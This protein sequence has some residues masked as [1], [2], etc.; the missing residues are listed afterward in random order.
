MRINT[1]RIGALLFAAA[2]ISAPASAQIVQSL[3]FGG[4]V[5][6]P[7]GEDS[8]ASG[9]VLATDLNEGGLTFRL[10]DLN[11]GHAFGEWLVGVG[12][13]L[14]FGA[15]LGFSSGSA[16]SFYT[17][18]AHPDGS[19]ITQDLKLRTVPITGVVRFLANRPGMFQP[20]FG[21]GIAAVN[22]R[23]TESGEFAD[24]GQVDST[25]AFV[26]FPATYTASGTAVGPVVLAGFRVPLG[27]DIWGFTMEWRHYGLAGDA[28]TGNTGGSN[29]GFLADKI[30][31]G[32]SDINFGLLLRF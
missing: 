18:Y 23:Y 5:F 13:H 1:G 21:V 28:P 2:L 10:S 11:S 27:G 14:E 26:T 29:A 7:R 9:D 31:L 4:G 12:D 6:V 20:Y 17:D 24:F 25:G 22:F 30:D 16:R 19:D 32:G 3:H 8:R 15:G